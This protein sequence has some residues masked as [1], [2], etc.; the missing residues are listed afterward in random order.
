MKKSKVYV[1]G[2]QNENENI[3]PINYLK[4]LKN[5]NNI[6]YVDLIINTKNAYFITIEDEGYL[7]GILSLSK[8]EASEWLLQSV[9]VAKNERRKGNATL[10]IQSFFEF[11]NKNIKGIIYQSSYSEMGEKYLHPIFNSIKLFYPNVNF[12]DN[13][14]KGFELIK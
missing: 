9:D 11:A 1:S 7:I 14:K 5:T 2:I 3:L 4:K 10:L 13:N 8:L 12:V 6:H